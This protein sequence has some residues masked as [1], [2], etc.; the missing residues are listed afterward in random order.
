MG[1]SSRKL[2]V[3]LLLD[4]ANSKADGA[5]GRQRPGGPGHNHDGLGV[6][7]WFAA[8]K[9]VPA[10]SLLAELPAGG[11][12]GLVL[13]VDLT[14]SFRNSH[15]GAHLWHDLAHAFEDYGLDIDR[16]VTGRLGTH[17]TVQ[18][19]V[20]RSATGTTTVDSV[21]ALRTKNKKAASDLFHDLRRVSERAKLGTPLTRDS[22]DPKDRRTHELLSLS[23][24][25]LVMFVTAH[26]DAL[27]FATGAESLVSVVD[28]MR[29]NKPR[30][31]KSE[32]MNAALA[33]AGGDNVAGLFDVELQPLFD[34]I[35]GAIAGTGARV[36]LSTLP[37]R[38][39]GHLD[40]QRR[41][42]GT[43]VRVR[44][45]SSK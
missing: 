12:G 15:D 8:V 43:V 3:M 17:G 40:L 10:R 21:Y 6:D 42:D 36:D 45:L 34:Q 2:L 4:F 18:F 41:D 22:K 11:L 14:T 32:P 5:G 39:V 35:M 23:H 20:G 16:N 13:S 25:D 29:R 28:E 30:T 26:E 44:V 38:H 19:H 37:K 33:A 27:V 9:P 7:G 1:A 31:R 24:N